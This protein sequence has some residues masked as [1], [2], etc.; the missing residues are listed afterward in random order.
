[1]TVLSMVQA[2]GSMHLSTGLLPAPIPEGLP[3]LKVAGRALFRLHCRD[4][5]VSADG[6]FHPA[7]GSAFRP[8]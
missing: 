7:S 8:I 5:Q 1:M 2:G 6:V 4:T 3:A